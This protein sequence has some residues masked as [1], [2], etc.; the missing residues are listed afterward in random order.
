MSCLRPRH[1]V[2]SVK[3]SARLL[4]GRVAARLRAANPKPKT[5]HRLEETFS[6]SGI[7]RATNGWLQTADVQF[8]TTKR[9]E[10]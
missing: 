9:N 6:W 5:L 4:H 1:R 2:L 7:L 8:G 3:Q 10:F